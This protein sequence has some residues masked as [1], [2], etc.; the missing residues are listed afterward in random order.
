MIETMPLEKAPEAC[1]KMMAGKARFSYGSQHAILYEPAMT[2]SL[3]KQ[4][5]RIRQDT[6]IGRMVFVQ[7]QSGM[8]RKQRRRSLW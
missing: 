6:S 3:E 7:V 2:M 4:K 5:R 1:A 8:I